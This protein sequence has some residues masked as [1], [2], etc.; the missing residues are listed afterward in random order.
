MNWTGWGIDLQDGSIR[1]F[2]GDARWLFTGLAD[3]GNL[4]RVEFIR[5]HTRR[6]SQLCYLPLPYTIQCL[7][8]EVFSCYAGNTLRR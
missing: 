2:C 7:R 3:H 5:D 8:T 1:L 4:G 6:W